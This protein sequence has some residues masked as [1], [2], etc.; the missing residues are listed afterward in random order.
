M[1]GVDRAAAADGGDRA[2]VAEVAGDH[3]GGPGRPR[4]RASRPT[5]ATRSG[6]RCRG[7]RSGGCRGAGRARRAG[8]R[9][10]P[11]RSSSGGTRCR[12]PPPAAPPQELARRP[13]ALDVGRIVE[14]GEVEALLDALEHVVVDQHR[15]LKRSPPWTMRCPTASISERLRIT[16]TS[17]RV[18][19]AST[20]STAILCSRIS[21]VSRTA[22]RPVGLV[23]KDR[24]AHR[25]S[26]RGPSPAPG[27]CRPPLGLV[28]LDELELDGGAATVEDQYLHGVI[29]LPDLVSP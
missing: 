12:T 21:P 2:A 4:G 3:A 6:G 26:R 23:A 24:R 1:R 5:A 27:R 20:R 17:S 11:P 19:S 29:L 15:A 22:G 7:S 18:S 28:G 16:P 10:T 9:G 25:C 13:V 14:R 8:R